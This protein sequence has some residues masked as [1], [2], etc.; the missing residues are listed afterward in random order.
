MNVGGDT[1]GRAA[2]VHVS[3]GGVVGRL[4]R[5]DLGGGALDPA[6]GG[7]AFAPQLV[8]FVEFQWCQLADYARQQV[9]CQLGVAGQARAVQIGGDDAALHRAVEAIAVAV[10]GTA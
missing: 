7:Q 3:A 5:A 9:V 4:R 6:R 10:A 8:H 1:P 2:D